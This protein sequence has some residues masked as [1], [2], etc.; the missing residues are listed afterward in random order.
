MKTYNR[1]EAF[2]TGSLWPILPE[3]MDTIMA[4]VADRSAEIAVDTE[5]AEKMVA[6]NKGTRAKVARSVAVL[7]VVGVISQRMNL[8]TAI[9]GGSSTELLGREFD[10]LVADGSVDAIVL[11]VDSPGGNYYG[12]P[13]LASKIMA[14][15]GSKPIVAVANSMAASAAYWIASACDEVVVT[16]S[17]DV[18]SIGVLAVHTDVSGFNEQV[19]VKHEYVTYGRHKA[20]GNSDN[21]LSADTREY[22]QQQV[23]AAGR[24]F[25]KAVA[26]HRGTTAKAV[27]DTFG[28]GRMFNAK[29]AIGLGM[30]DRIG[31]LESEIDRLASAQRVRR[32]RRIERARLGLK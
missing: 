16:P 32:G 30:A 12:T 20:E 31:T 14:A 25:D 21:P 3:K 27:H 6:A 2:I 29:D 8:M 13:E 17:G 28:Q 10:A 26:A 24:T 22:L 23:D 18:G 1:I 19:G 11:D 5:V 9:S 15:R 4:L 7:P